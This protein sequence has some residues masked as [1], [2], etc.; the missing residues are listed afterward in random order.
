L[1]EF[2]LSKFA[3]KELISLQVRVLLVQLQN[4]AKHVVVIRS[5]SL[6]KMVQI[7]NLDLVP[8]QWLLALMAFT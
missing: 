2:A 3:H 1:Q 4:T 6:A 8:P 7:L 5:V